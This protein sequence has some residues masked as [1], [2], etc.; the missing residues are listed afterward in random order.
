[1]CDRKDQRLPRHI[2]LS[3]QAFNS[4]RP[5]R[6]RHTR[7]DRSKSPARGAIPLPWHRGPLDLGGAEFVF[8]ELAK[9]IEL[10]V[11]QEVVRRLRHSRTGRTVSDHKVTELKSAQRSHAA[12]PGFLGRE[13][14]GTGARRYC[15]QCG[16]EDRGLTAMVARAGPLGGEARPGYRAPRIEDG[17]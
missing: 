5:P 4:I 7:P 9:R 8:R 14:G 13:E 2:A 17:G 11:S 12:G 3:L 16:P 6:V 1:M 15:V 10:R